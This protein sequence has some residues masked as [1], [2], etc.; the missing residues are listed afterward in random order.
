MYQESAIDRDIA[1]RLLLPG[2]TAW[3]AYIRDDESPNHV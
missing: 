1:L 2:G 3:L